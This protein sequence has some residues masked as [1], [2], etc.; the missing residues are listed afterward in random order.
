MPLFVQDLTSG[1]PS[2]KAKKEMY[3][4]KKCI[5][6]LWD[7]TICSTADAVSTPLPSAL[8][9]WIEE[10]LVLDGTSV[11]DLVQ[12]IKPKILPTLEE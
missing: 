12:L 2:L 11:Q 6:V 8:A 1:N 7:L 9:R 10:S 4:K 3:R 5:T